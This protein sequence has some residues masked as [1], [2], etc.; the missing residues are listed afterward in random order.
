MSASGGRRE[1]ALQ[2]PA[3]AGSAALVDGE[4]FCLNI[5][6]AARA[7]N[8]RFDDAFR[9]LGIGSGQFSVMMLLCDDH[10]LSIG[11]LAS[12]VGCDRTTVTALLK[13]LLRRGLVEMSVDRRDSRRKCVV[14][15]EEGADLLRQALPLWQ[16]LTASIGDAASLEGGGLVAALRSL[17]SGRHGT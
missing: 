3:L 4:C 13:P 14:L 12:R 1:M 9:P 5:N 10:A 8:R 17:S 6:R 11:Q 7:M 16:Q 15:R 2:F